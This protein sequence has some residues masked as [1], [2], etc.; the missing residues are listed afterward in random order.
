MSISKAIRD[1]LLVEAQHRC[2]ICSERCF[3]IH[4]IVEQS[5]GG[6]D[7]P[8]NLIVMCPNCHQH[9][10]HRCGE[11]TRD[12]L[13]MYKRQLQERAEIEKRLLQNL[14]DIRV[15]VREK[16]AREVQTELLKELTNAKALINPS[17]TPRLAQSIQEAAHEMAEESILPEAARQAIELEFEIER[18]RAK[19]EFVDVSVAGVDQGA[20]K[21]SNEFPRAYEFAVTLN[22]RPHPE[23]NKVF[24]YQYDSSMYLMKRQTRVSGTRIVL[25][26]ADSDNLQS[27][28][29]WIKELVAR[30]NTWIRQEGFMNIDNQVNRAKNRALEEFDAIQSMKDRTKN[31]KV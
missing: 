14:D 28:I 27:H 24:Q 7:Q 3:E 2:T 11:F 29:D 13:R 31:L 22:T 1:Q 6:N 17:R 8:D 20:Y 25:I 9:R 30:T 15:A 4:H 18:E 12:Q 23:W 26:V 16:N 5:E 10:Y 21:K 19:A